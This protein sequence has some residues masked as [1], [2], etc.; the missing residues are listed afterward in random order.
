[1]KKNKKILS[2]IL[3]FIAILALPR[4]AAIAENDINILTTSGTASI[5]AEPDTAIF[6]VAVET[7][8]P[9]LKDAL[10]E[11][12]NK[13]QKVI[14]EIKKFLG[15]D[16]SIKTTGFNVKPVYS[17]DNKERKSVLTAYRV[18]NMVNVKIKKL[19]D[20]GKIIDTAIKNGANKADDLDFT[21]ENKDKYSNELLKKAS[22]Q[23]KQK[24]NATAE[25]LGLRIKGINRVSTS[26]SDETISPYY[27]GSFSSMEMKSDA[28][29]A[30]PPIE[31]GEVKLKAIV[32][33][34]FIIENLK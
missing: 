7:E 6:S 21:V 15:K 10:Q 9:L 22:E 33:V 8:K 25:A 1:M 18:T 5:N 12:T 24:A 16:D 32:S 17:Y 4:L 28:L 29:G 14:A 31:A 3:V 19:S 20:T 13:S 11:N 26:F 34:D 30:S 2:T 23:A 27:R